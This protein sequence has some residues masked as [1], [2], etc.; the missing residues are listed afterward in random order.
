MTISANPPHA[1]DGR[2]GR[3]GYPRRVRGPDEQGVET[4]DEQ[5]QE[6]KRVNGGKGSG[7]DKTGTTQRTWRKT[8]DR[9]E[10]R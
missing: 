4:R 8:A 9:N 1:A 6:S 2:M 5:K 7:C 3:R 10:R